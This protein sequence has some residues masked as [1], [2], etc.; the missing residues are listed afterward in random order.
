MVAKAESDFVDSIFD[1][2]GNLKDNYI[3]GAKK[4]ATLTQD[5]TGFAEGLEKVFNSQPW[6]KPFFLFARTGV[7]G[8]NLTAKHTP[9][10]NFLVDEWN[11]I[12]FAKPGDFSKVAK[13]GIETA[14]D[15]ANARAIQ[16]G[17]LAM[18]SAVIFMAGQKFL[19]GELHG[20][21]PADRQKRQT[22]LD[23]GWRP[24]TMKFGDVWVSYDSFEPFN[25]ILSIIGDI[26]DHQELM[27]EEWAT[28]Q[29]QKLSLVVAQGITSKSYMAGL[30]QFV[31]IFAGRPG[32]VNRML[33]QMA[34]NTLPLSS[35]R[36]ELGKVFTPYTRELGSDIESSIR[37]RNLLSE[38]IASEPLPIKY[39]ML[40]GKPI[41][42][43]DF[44]TRMFNAFSPVQ[45][46][47]DYS[48]GRKMLFDSGYDLRQSTYYAPDGTNLSKSPILRSLFQKA[49]GEQKI[50]LKLDKLAE[51]EGIQESIAE[52]E[53]DRD[54]GLRHVE[55]KKYAHNSR[56]K[57]IFDKAKSIAWA[58]VKQDPR[59]QKLIAEERQKEIDNIQANRRSVQAILN[60]PK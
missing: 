33:A 34:N 41:K 20:N 30:Q 5:L 46:N 37:N 7:N 9:I 28:D 14:E 22:W 56:I 36:N 47:M 16:A 26:G 35:F 52:M 10:F 24:R 23:A 12:A 27:G 45:L 29:L 3:K 6:A 31:D 53:Y 57:S 40:T 51:N 18:G 1:A 54:N 25:Q 55:P 13:Y 17:R 59:A 42:D 44:I 32:S 49:I 50:I 11:D 39:D 58:K 8:L 2:E 15:L 4:E 48:P 21:G 19:S 38:A 60:I 43:H